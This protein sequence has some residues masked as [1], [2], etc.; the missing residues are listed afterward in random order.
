MW[1]KYKD[2]KE[3][4]TKTN[5][6]VKNACNVNIFMWFFRTLTKAHSTGIVYIDVI[7]PDR[8][9]RFTH[10]VGGMLAETC[11]QRYHCGTQAPIWMVDHE[12]HP[13]GIYDSILRIFIITDICK[14]ML[15]S[16]YPA[17]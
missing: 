11:V 13:S 16:L 6:H 7:F 1:N 12:K 8:W 15:R 4:S 14:F 2:H 10:R 5:I 9:H 17:S 3:H